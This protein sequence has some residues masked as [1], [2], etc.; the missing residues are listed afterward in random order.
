VTPSLPPIGFVLLLAAALGGCID[1]A[2]PILSGAKPEFGPTLRLH[3]FGLRD[4]FA[5]DPEQATYAWNGTH[6]AHAG[7]GMTDVAGF[8]LFP[9]ERGDFVAQSVPRDRD[10]PVEYALVHKLADGVFQVLPVDEDDADAATR[11]AHCRTTQQ[12][13]CR[14]E[15]KDQLFALT[16]AT[17]GRRGSTGGLAIVLA[18][19]R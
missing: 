3:A 15:T 4:G 12:W 10:G 18:P 16:H 13:S 1:S 14:I 17:A 11:T 6:Y 2:R 7:G 8:S 9:F 5:H 19:E